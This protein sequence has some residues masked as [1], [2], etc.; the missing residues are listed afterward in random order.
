VRRGWVQDVLDPEVFP[1][2][3]VPVQR[4]LSVLDGRI[5]LLDGDPT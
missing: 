1:S 4:A 2:V 5:V 3:P